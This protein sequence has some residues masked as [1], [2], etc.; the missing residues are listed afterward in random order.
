M[1]STSESSHPQNR[2]SL[3]RSLGSD[4]L[5]FSFL[6]KLLTVFQQKL[7]ILL[8][9]CRHLSRLDGYLLED[10]EVNLTIIHI[11]I[12]KILLHLVTNLENKSTSREQFSRFRKT[13]LFGMRYSCC[14]FLTA[15]CVKEQA[16]H[17]C[18][19]STLYVRAH[20]ILNLKKIQLRISGPVSEEEC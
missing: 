20:A 15:S 4:T 14:C 6:V 2:Y 16:H 18:S 19:L 9:S 11:L 5:S 1:V 12:R 3:S 7:W 17:M 8:F 13:S 10:L